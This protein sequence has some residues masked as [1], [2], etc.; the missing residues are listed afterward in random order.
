MNVTYTLCNS[1]MMIRLTVLR[2]TSFYSNDIN[3][4]LY[5]TKR[6][7]RRQASFLNFERNFRKNFA[8]TLKF[9]ALTSSLK[10]FCCFSR[11]AFLLCFAGARGAYVFSAS[12]AW[13]IFVE[14]LSKSCSLKWTHRNVRGL[15]LYVLR[16]DKTLSLSYAREYKMTAS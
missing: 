4:C 16:A 12:P 3:Q 6:H 9:P 5:H 8:T 1:E 10:I 11:I 13:I 7:M 15:E 14:N 2:K